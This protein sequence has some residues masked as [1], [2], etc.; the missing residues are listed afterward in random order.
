MPDYSYKAADSSGTVIKGVYFANNGQELAN[1]LKS[2][3]LHLIEFKEAG[4]LQLLKIFGDIQIGGVSRLE[5]V[6]F[7]NNMGIMFKAGVPLVQSLNELREDLENKYF[8]KALGEIIEDIESGDSLYEAMEKKPRIFPELYIRVVEIGESTGRMDHAFF[9]L[10]RHYKRID[11]LI[12]NVR[13]AMI[14]PAFVVLALIGASFV[15]LTM[16]FPPLF[17]MLADFDVPL[18]TITK[19]VMAVSGVLK[20]HW[21]ILLLCAAVVIVLFIVLRRYKTTKYYMDWCELNIPYVRSLLMQLRMSFFMRYFAMLLSSGMDM[22]RSLEL[23]TASVNNLV[24]QKFLTSS[25]ERV[26]EGEFLSDALR[27]KRFVPNMVT[28]MVGIGEESGNLPEQMEYVAD[29]YNDELE[30]RI[31]IALAL[32]EPIL[33]IIMAGMALA[34]IMGVLLPLYNLV[35]QLS[36]GVGAGGGM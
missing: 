33:L 18:P 28:R 32:M 3:G 21:L 26:I 16:V 13:K 29:H 24:V 36:M 1:Y 25:R 5:L 20:N 35:S 30:R 8:K 22:L 6:E 23:A 9:D 4:A 34:L 7:S 11:D 31:T 15:F 14:Y 19:V 10:A 12:K 2:A 27:N 17:T